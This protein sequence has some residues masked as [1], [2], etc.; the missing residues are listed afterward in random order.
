MRERIGDFE[1]RKDEMKIEG[2]PDGSGS[3]H[4]IELQK[5][6]LMENTQSTNTEMGERKAREDSIELVTWEAGKFN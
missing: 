6:D 2:V 5:P 3:N 4:D 1:R